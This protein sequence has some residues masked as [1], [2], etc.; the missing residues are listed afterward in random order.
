MACVLDLDLFEI[1]TTTDE[2]DLGA[3]L[4]VGQQVGDRAFFKMRQQFGD[5]NTTEFLLEY[6]LADLLRVQTTAAPDC[7]AR[8]TASGSGASSARGSI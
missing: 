6:Q 1:T 8:P 5:R 3:G 4:T 7:L 2:G